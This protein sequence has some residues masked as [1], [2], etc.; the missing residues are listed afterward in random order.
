MMDVL[1]RKAPWFDT[2]TCNHFHVGRLRAPQVLC[3]SAP[4]LWPCLPFFALALVTHISRV[5]S[6]Q[7]HLNLSASLG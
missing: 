2:L 6:E 5:R 7:A 3:L 4:V 1:G